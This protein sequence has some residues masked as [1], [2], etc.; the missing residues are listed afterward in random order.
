MSKNLRTALAVGA[1]LALPLGMAACGGD[2]GG[3]N[4]VPG[5]AIASVDGTPISRI[6]YEHWYAVNA[7]GSSAIGGPVVIPDPP[8]Y[9]R[10]VVLMA[11]ANAQAA[12]AMGR[13]PARQTAAQLRAE[14][15]TRH[16]T[17]RDSTVR[18]L[19]QMAWLERE[20]ERVGIEATDAEIER[21]KREAYPRAADLRRWLR[22]TGM[23]EADVEF[24]LRFSQYGREISEAVRDDA[25][26]SVDDAQVDAY[27]ARNR[28]AFA[29][30]ERRDLQL[31][32]T[33]TEAQANAAKRAAESGTAWAAVARRW[34]TD[35][36]SKANG[37]TLSG[38]ARGQQDA[39]LDRAAFGA[40]AGEI[41]GPVRGANG[42]YVVRVTRVAPAKQSSLAESR[43][44]IRTTLVAQRGDRAIGDYARSFQDRWTERT[45]CGS[46]YVIALCSNAPRA[47]T[48]TA[49]GTVAGRTTQ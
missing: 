40:A 42:W 14:C 27:Y 17:I 26:R 4:D 47:R 44:Q 37:G 39:A 29:L 19:L 28:A 2:E 1:L 12:E 46:G 41:A 25:T 35:A 32:L 23:T 36:I 11:R 18:Q 8:S 9:T 3:N 43:E 38:V 21:A 15:R 31:V 5:D 22:Q 34:S 10:C 7:R 45:A 20:A 6:D 49:G 13:R 48:T 33:R 16:E 24:Q 30:P